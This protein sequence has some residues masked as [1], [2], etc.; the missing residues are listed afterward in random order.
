MIRN[1]KIENHKAISFNKYNIDL[2][3]GLYINNKYVQS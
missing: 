2:W 1:K 3:Y